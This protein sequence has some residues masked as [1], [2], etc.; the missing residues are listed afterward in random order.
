MNPLISKIRAQ[1]THSLLR[2]LNFYGGAFSKAVFIGFSLLL[3]FPTNLAA[4]T[5]T[6]YSYSVGPAIRNIPKSEYNGVNQNWSMT[7]AE[8]GYI[9]IANRMGL[10]E[11]NGSKWELHSQKGGNQMRSV[12]ALNKDFI[13]YGYFEDF[14]YYERNK[15]G[16]LIQ[17]SISDSLVT[18]KEITN[19]DIWSINKVGNKI[20]FRSFGKIYVF[21]GH[22]IDI[23]SPTSNVF[24]FFEYQG[25]PNI[26][27]LDQG[28]FSISDNNFLQQLSLPNFLVKNRIITILPLKKSQ[29]I[30]I[31]EFDGIFIK[32]DKEYLS[33][34][35]E[36]NQ[37][38][39]NYQIN[40]AVV[41]DD[42]RFAIGTIG[43]GVIIFDSNGQIITF[44]DKSNGLQSNNILS[45]LTDKDRNL[46]IGSNGGID[47]VNMNSPFL[48]CLDKSG[49]LGTIICAIVYNNR[50]Y[51]GSNQGLFFSDEDLKT[52]RNRIGFEKIKEVKGLVWDL[53]I[54][55][56]NLFCNYNLGILQINE[57]GIKQ[58]GNVGGYTIIKHPRIEN[59]YYQGN[60][61]GIL[62]FKKEKDGTLNASNWLHYS[63]GGARSLF[64]DSFDN[65]WAGESFKN[66]R[67]FHLN[68]RGDSVIKSKVF[69][70]ESGFDTNWKVNLHAFENRIVFAN[71]N[72][73]YTYDYVTE[74][75]QP[76]VWLK[77]EIGA[78]NTSI[79]F[80]QTDSNEYWFLQRDSYGMF[81]FDG[82]KLNL[83]K[84]LK[85]PVLSSIDY[86]RQNIWKLDNSRYIVGF[87]NGFM[88]YNSDYKV[89]HVNEYNPVLQFTGATC[90]NMQGKVNNLEIKNVKSFEIPYSFRNL[91]INYSVPGLLPETYSIEYKLND[92]DW[93][94]N[95]SSK[96]IV[97][98]FLKFQTHKLTVRALYENKQTFS[99]LICEI[100]ISSP[101]FLDIYAMAA[102]LILFAG[103]I[104][105]IK[106]VNQKWLKKEKLSYLKKVKLNNEQRMIQMKTH[107]LETEIQNKS[108]QLVN[109]TILLSKKNEV[110]IQI[111]ENLNHFFKSSVNADRKIILPIFNIIDDNLSD[112]NDW[113]ILSTHFDESHS[114]FLKKLMSEQ[115]S[116]TPNDLKLCMFLKMNLTSKEIASLLNISYRSVEVKRYRLRKKLGLKM[117]ANLVEFLMKI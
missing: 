50:L 41:I 31:T 106:F 77:K 2:N 104:Y 64:I 1:F 29:D 55:D 65:L 67:F 57:K 94:S 80:M 62:M 83:S 45:L 74:S 21:D 53:K 97:F 96:S 28:I 68:S 38:L 78:Y 99:E 37:I 40:K 109:Y 114:D 19:Q 88:I 56:N 98:N 115:P 60:Y 9:F 89:S 35:S 52:T 93:L 58:I 79:T 72:D 61:L 39:K 49:Q 113:D 22:K 103:L 42:N 112:K 3:S 82:T 76:Y 16:K 107:Y 90:S 116:L 27:L 33:W 13:Y 8:N 6:H 54:I 70:K 44:L 73:L 71:N 34:D 85:N 108:T 111:K 75:I 36:V 87:D 11:F 46:W 30:I 95:G 12:L 81:L 24:N 105:L 17:H 92:D 117:E 14:G 102:Y 23:I 110:L 66:A 18:H 10:I 48:Y 63:D 5:T 43:N 25:K 86:D 100:K 7:Q 51:L 26:S 84:E 59:T 47:F 69:G 20:Y 4:E 15:F 91:T 101:W 32:K